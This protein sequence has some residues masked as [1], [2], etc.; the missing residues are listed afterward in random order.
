MDELVKFVEDHESGE[1]VD[2]E[3]EDETEEGD[4]SEE[5]PQRDEL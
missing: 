5:E 2:D 3:S 1:E 4:P